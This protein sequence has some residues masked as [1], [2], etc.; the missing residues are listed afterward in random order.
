MSAVALTVNLDGEHVVLVEVSKVAAPGL[1][2]Q[3]EA[4]L[5]PSHG[6]GGVVRSVVDL[7]AV[8]SKLP[9]GGKTF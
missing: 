9:D 8:D 5:V 7:G 3:M 2:E 6:A 1:A 4:C